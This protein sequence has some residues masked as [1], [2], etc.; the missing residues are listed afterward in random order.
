[1]DEELEKD[2]DVFIGG[3]KREVALMKQNG[4]LDYFEGKYYYLK[5]C[6][7]ILFQIYSSMRILYIYRET[8]S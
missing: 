2:I 1:M 6:I 5:K 4:E 3:Y 8:A 7:V